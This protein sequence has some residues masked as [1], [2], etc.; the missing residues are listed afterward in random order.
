MGS[1]FVD[2]ASKCVFHNI[3]MQSSILFFSLILFTFLIQA[4]GASPI[5]VI[6]KKEQ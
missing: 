5:V 6:R 3:I 4:F 1:V 2:L